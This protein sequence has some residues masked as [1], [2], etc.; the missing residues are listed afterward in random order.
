MFV[1]SNTAL[2]S[3]VRIGAGAM[4][5][6]GSVITRDV[7][8]GD[9]ALSRARQENKNG[10]GAKLMARLRAMKAAGKRP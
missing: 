9:L 7:P 5:G 1:G 6:S 10:L 4:V 8:P 2:V 3:P